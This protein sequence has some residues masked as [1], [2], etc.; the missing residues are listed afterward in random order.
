M[1][2]MGVQKMSSEQRLTEQDIALAHASIA[3]LIAVMKEQAVLLGHPEYLGEDTFGGA[4]GAIAVQRGAAAS[5]ELW[6]FWP[7]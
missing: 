6:P 7:L 2:S 5:F 3:K 4:R 1:I